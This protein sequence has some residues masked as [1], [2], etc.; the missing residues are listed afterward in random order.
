MHLSAA[1]TLSQ[2]SD[3]RL[4]ILDWIAAQGGDRP[5]VFI[6]LGPLFET[7]GELDEQ[8]ALAAELQDMEAHG[9][10]IVDNRLGYE[11][12]S[13]RTTAEGVGLLGEVRMRRGDPVTRRRDARDALLR[14]VYHETM[15]GRPSSPVSGFH[16]S[17]YAVNYGVPFT[18]AEISDSGVWLRDGGY[19]D[20]EGSVHHPG[21][22]FPTLT[23]AGERVV[24]SGRSV[25][26]E[27]STAADGRRPMVTV[28][29]PQDVIEAVARGVARSGTLTQED[30][31]LV[32]AVAVLLEASF[33]AVQADAADVE[34][35]A[36]VVRALRGA[37][38]Q[39]DA[40]RERLRALLDVARELAVQAVGGAAGTGVATLAQ[41]CQHMLGPL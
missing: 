2:G 4:A 8:R 31:Q 19:V 3:R 7:A 32:L 9:W 21:P 11:D 23:T 41:I 14:W 16:S 12:W 30:R 20:G 10:L 13:C 1:F 27:A 29:V 38:R 24:E 5:N 36:D 37:A 28:T 15:A 33:A 35:V 39:P 18:E 22:L 25:N 34:K 26:D 17:R 6:P 40:D